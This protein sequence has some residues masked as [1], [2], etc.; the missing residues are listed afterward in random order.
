[1]K[2]ATTLNAKSPAGGSLRCEIAEGGKRVRITATQKGIEQVVELDDVT[3]TNLRSLLF[4][5][6]LKSK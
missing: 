6:F 3:V 4:D 2:I 1:M 5:A